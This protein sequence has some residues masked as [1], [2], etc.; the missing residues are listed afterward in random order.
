MPAPARGRG[1]YVS[2]HGLGYTAFEHT[3]EGIFTETFM[4]VS[5]QAPLKFVAVTIRNTSAA[6]AGCP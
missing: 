5:P 6:P 3:E 2:R 1:A 4:Y